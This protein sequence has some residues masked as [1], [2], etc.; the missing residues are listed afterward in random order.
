MAT[1][2][3]IVLGIITFLL[4]S[5]G[6][7]Y[8]TYSDQVRFRIDNDKTSLYLPHE[9]YP[10]IW[11]VQAREY[12]SLFDGTSKMNRNL[13][14]IFVSSS[15]DSITNQST[16]IRETS[17]I[18]GPKIKDTYI[19][20]GE[21]TSKKF[22]PISHQIEIFNGSGLFY[23]YEIRELT[24]DFNTTKL[25]GETEINLQNNVKVN[26]EEDY[27]WAWIYKSGILK[28][29]YDIQ[30][31]YEIYN[32]RLFDP[33]QYV[34][35]GNSVYLDNSNVLINIT[36]HTSNNPIIN[37]TTK[38]FTGDVD[39]VFG[40]DTD[41]VKPIS[42]KTSPYKVNIDK[43]Y[44]C[45]YDFNYTLTPKHF[46]CYDEYDYGNGTSG[47]RIFFEHD[48]D[49][50]DI[51]KKT[52]Y[53]TET[54]TIWNDVSG[55]FNKLTYDYQ[56]FDTWYYK[57]NIPVVAGVSRLL[58][59]ELES[60]GFDNLSYKYFFGVKPSSETLS[61]A[62]ANNHFYYIDPWTAGLSNGLVFYFNLNEDTG[63]SVED[64]VTGTYNTSFVGSAAWVDGIID[65]AG[66][67]SGTGE[68]IAATYN[69]ITNWSV[70]Q[71]VY[72]PTGSSR[73]WTI[74]SDALGDGNRE[75]IAMQIDDNPDQQI[76]FEINDGTWDIGVANVTM[77]DNTWTHFCGTYDGTNDLRKLYV[78]GSIVLADSSVGANT[79]LSTI[80]FQRHNLGTNVT[81]DEI[82]FW[83]RTLTA[84]ECGQLYGAR[85]P[86]RY[87]K[88]VDSSAPT[89]S[90]NQTNSTLKATSILHSLLWADD[91]ALAGYIFSYNN[92][93]IDKFTNDSWVAFTGTLNWSNVTKVIPDEIS[94]NI[95]W[96]IY[97]NDSSNNWNISKLFSY[98][99]TAD[100]TCT[101]SSG[102]WDVDCSDNCT[103]SSNVALGGNNLT[104]VG[105]GHFLLGA[106]ITG[107]NE[108]WLGSGCEIWQQLNTHFWHT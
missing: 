107:I 45:E 80:S 58:K 82:A 76:S 86:P 57:K 98:V 65:S 106:N 91:T 5:S 10:W 1:T 54:K 24:G 46:W 2:Q 27:R 4:L 15:F 84:T 11:T 93:N 95:S 104:L 71:W 26:L 87:P 60:K 21:V 9:N 102:N 62:I 28:A 12:N 90:A 78:N 70:S 40:F 8:V 51:S 96:I 88:P 75:V 42:A 97:A 83:N 36:P 6:V 99:S 23:R 44:T 35:E 20:D 108:R 55:E 25:T 32:I 68:Y 41:I 100:D 39:I 77:L 101:Y 47:T 48:F 38:S 105:I 50:G 18:R 22:F 66:E 19:F 53:W 56:D 29:Q 74:F 31:D 59:V 64:S 37:F 94:L 81:L 85:S 92:G 52:A 69:F 72:Y 63:T 30:T 33:P 3:K 14:S 34:I 17:Y 89:S 67:F 13:S 73:S 103:I 49:S 61:Q 43:N 16:I 7:V 79:G